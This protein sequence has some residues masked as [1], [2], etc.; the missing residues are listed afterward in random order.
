MELVG[1]GVLSLAE[2][3]DEAPSSID[4]C[5]ID[6]IELGFSGTWDTPVR[7]V[8]TMLLVKLEDTPCCHVLEK[9]DTQTDE[10]LG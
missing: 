6:N 10:L 4:D 8:E 1:G 7:D 2:E 9:E 3:G 5:V